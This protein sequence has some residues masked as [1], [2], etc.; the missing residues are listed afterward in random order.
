MSFWRLLIGGLLPALLVGC[1]AFSNNEEIDPPAELTDF[2]AELRLTKIWDQNTGSGLATGD[3]VL[4]PVLGGNFIYTADPRGRILALDKSSGR[5]QWRT[6][7]DTHITGSVALTPSLVLVGSQDGDLYALNRENGRVAWSTRLSSEVLAAADGNQQ[8]VVVS[9]Q[10]GTLHALNADDGSLRWSQD[11]QKPL[12]TLRGNGQPRVANDAVYIGLDNGKVVAHRLQDGGL[13]WEAR[14]ALPE[15]TTELA[16][17]VDVDTR[18]LIFGGL[19]FAVGY[20]GGLMAIDLE[21]GRS[22]WFQEGSSRKD[23]AYFGGLLVVTMLDG[24]LVSYSVT[25]GAQIW[26]SSAFLNRG[27]TAPVAVDQFVAVGEAEAGYLHLLNRRT[28]SEIGRVKVDS[29][30]ISATPVSDGSNLYVLT[31]D[32]KLTA[33]AVQPI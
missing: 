2:S 28:G 14:V 22:N 4:H 13:L 1:S 12:L 9:T 11:I 18:P 21:S 29:S 7:L 30:G 3:M 8:V 32:G 15:G 31:R 6:D 33:Y 17:M 26:E 16:R 5:S 10:D 23:L 25:T 27:I 20:Q 24:R 19:I